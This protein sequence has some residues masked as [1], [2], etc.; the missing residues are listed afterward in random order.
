MTK[1]RTALVT[2]A[3]GGI[4]RAVAL[5]LAARGDNVVVCGRTIQSLRLVLAE[6]EQ[7]GGHGLAVQVDVRNA[8]TVD[9]LFEEARANFGTVDILVT[10]AV[11][12]R[13]A[14]F[15]ELTDD[16]WLTHYETKVLGAV[17]CIRQV[18]PLMA[19]QQWGR[20]VNLAGTSARSSAVRRMT[21]GMTNA[22]LTNISK[23]LAEEYADQGVLI[24]TI[25]PGFTDSS[26]LDMIIG[27][28]AIE[29]NV[30][31]LKARAQLQQQIPT[32]R[33]VQPAE[34]ADLVSFLCSELNQSITGQV[35]AV[36][37]GLSSSVTY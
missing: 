34:I 8:A 15:L 3:S 9:S 22:A 13:V 36:D 25:H 19:Q 18:L 31:K 5:A 23:N 21:N 7:A 11:K 32:G 37:G 30:S 33:F 14:G 24:N 26:R 17:R 2:G 28:N 4:G 20:I 16:D 27:S 12:S 10:C 35:L 6:V 1:S 29:Q